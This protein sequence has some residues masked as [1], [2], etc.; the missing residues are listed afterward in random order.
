MECQ[1]RFQRIPVSK[2]EN[3]GMKVEIK[4]PC[5]AASMY[6]AD[7]WA[8]DSYYP[9]ST[10]MG[11][12]YDASCA[13][14]NLFAVIYLAFSC[15]I[16]YHCLCCD[17]F[18]EG[19][20]LSSCISPSKFG[21]SHSMNQFI[22]LVYLNALKEISLTDHPQVENV[23]SS[24]GV[25]L[26]YL[27]SNSL[28]GEIPS[29]IINHNF[30]DHHCDLNYFISSLSLRVIATPHKHNS[31][32]FCSNVVGTLVNGD[33]LLN[34][35]AYKI[36]R[37]LLGYNKCTEKVQDSK[38]YSTSFIVRLSRK[39]Y[40]ISRCLLGDNKCTEKF[41]DSKF[42]SA[43]FIARLSRSDEQIF[44]ILLLSNV[45]DHNKYL[46]MVLDLMMILK[47][48]GLCQYTSSNNKW[49]V[50][51]RGSFI[52]NLNGLQYTTQTASQITGT[53]DSELYKTAR[54]P[55]NSLRYYDLRLSN[56]GYNIELH[57]S[58]IQM[59]DSES[60]RGIGRRLFVIY[61]QVR[62]AG[63]LLST[64][65][66]IIIHYWPDGVNMPSE[67]HQKLFVLKPCLHRLVT[68]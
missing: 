26:R 41:Q 42:N 49:A 12:D 64:S 39:A 44:N 8:Y 35:K 63:Y 13:S 27:E 68:C 3:H 33:S 16:V 30:G 62:V 2:G 14:Q 52:S 20:A 65:L 15:T 18:F 45:V 61:I 38:F 55:P 53:L 36:S 28:N 1:F 17:H 32:F 60:W 54:I 21:G 66:I 40:K 47:S 10:L 56:R 57:F 58:E 29:N 34:G 43:S 46:H 4:L 50:S 19:F 51:N 59:E 31:T 23:R 5:G 37:C 11:T 48:S 67:W 24:Q 7:D 6:K 25:D 9:V 22:C